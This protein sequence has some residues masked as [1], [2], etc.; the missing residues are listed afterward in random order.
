MTAELMVPGIR[1]SPNFHAQEFVLQELDPLSSSKLALSHIAVAID[2]LGSI[3]LA[4]QLPGWTGL[5]A[6][7][8]RGY[9]NS[10]NYAIGSMSMALA[11]AASAVGLALDNIQGYQWPI[12]ADAAGICNDAQ[13]ERA[14]ELTLKEASLQLAGDSMTFSGAD[15]LMAD[16]MARGTTCRQGVQQS[17]EDLA[18]A[19]LTT[20]EDF[21]YLTLPVPSSVA[22]PVL[23]DI[24]TPVVG[25]ATGTGQ[26]PAALNALAHLTGPEYTTASDLRFHLE[27]LA[28][29]ER[30]W[31]LDHLPS[32]LITAILLDRSVDQLQADYEWW[33]KNL[34]VDQLTLIVGADPHGYFRPDGSFPEGPQNVFWGPAPG[35]ATPSHDPRGLT[36]GALGD[37]HLLA[38]LA[39]IA[40]SPGGD[41]FFQDNIDD[42]ANGTYT[43]TLYT[44][45]GASFEVTVLPEVVTSENYDGSDVVAYTYP[46]GGQLT[47]Y[48]IYEKALAQAS[49][50]GLIDLNSDPAGYPDLHFG[51]SVV[52]LPILTGAEATW[53]PSTLITASS[54]Q[55]ALADG[56]P[57]TVSTLPAEK[58][59]PNQY[60]IGQIAPV[61][62]HAYYVTSINMVDDP[63]TI[64]LGN[65]WGGEPPDGGTKDLVLTIDELQ[66]GTL[67]VTVGS[68]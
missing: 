34:P 59:K 8:Y 20:E 48:Q 13:F 29:A 52:D 38:G 45:L 61:A 9:L 67:G 31:L 28:P 30:E 22:D 49:A 37:C 18:A 3:L 11:N 10:L 25:S 35:D 23:H 55:Q 19:L 6:D 44:A 68:I 4:V 12:G 42:N 32:W 39:A 33:A 63:P 57:I 54:L 36:Q 53:T 43:V 60:F 64:T 7:T 15:T 50:A 27:G 47:A 51:S 2:R 66:N 26:T 24:F 5:A 62:S 40:I 17:L 65:P 58:S 46:F 1:W 16:G 56:R 41:R 21:S 14:R